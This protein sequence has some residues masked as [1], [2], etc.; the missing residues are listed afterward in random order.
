[1]LGKGE[2]QMKKTKKV[3]AILMALAICFALLA[4]CGDGSSDTPGGNQ[5][6]TS[7]GNTAAPPPTQ[8][9]FAPGQA[10][11]DAPAR[12]DGNFGEEIIIIVDNNAV[13]VLDPFMPG[14]GAPA[15][16][17]TTNL[18]FDRLIYP[19]GGGEY[20]PYLATRWET[21]DYKTFTFWLR[22]DVYFHNGEKFNAH[23]VVWTVN[24]AGEDMAGTNYS[25]W[26]PVPVVRVEAIEEYV[27]QIELQSVFIDYIFNI[28]QPYCLIVNEKA[29]RDDPVNGVMVGTGAFKFMEFVPS[30]YWI[31][32]RNDNYWSDLAIT[33]KITF[34]FIP[35]QGART[36]MMLNRE[37]E[38][39]FGIGGDDMHIFENH[40]DFQLYPFT[41]N[42]NNVLMFNLDDP[43]LSDYNLRM[44]II[45]GLNRADIAVVAAGAY[46]APVTDGNVWG[47]ETEF[48]L[49]DIPMI[50]EDENLAREFLA[51]SNYNG[52]PIEI[53][54]SILTNTRAAEMVQQLLLPLGINITLN[55]MDGAGLTAYND[56][57]NNQ[58]QLVIHVA[59]HT[60]AASSTRASVYPGMNANR[61]MYNNPQVTALYDR[62]VV[63]TDFNT[64]RDL[65]HQIQRILAEDPPRIN[66]FWRLNAAVAVHGIGGFSL[67]STALYDF[68]YL[69]WDLDQY[70]S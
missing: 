44:A 2:Y 64:R 38:L 12:Q 54:T 32:E 59:V 19:L 13:S 70:G 66:L 43:L 5:P 8:T 65:Y 33:R 18:I 36:V 31:V 58:S 61:V 27:V 57:A 3:V 25:F 10:A 47:Y 1:M 63:E 6:G 14:A 16:S 53:A 60:E 42:N 26:H 7:G 24:K 21:T 22:D 4:A 49:W 9:P 23:D 69:Y 11:P 17:W 52:E 67:P 41:F 50:A 30:N 39:C 28:A 40:D 35:E 46:A 51:R 56:P 68:R 15:N 48:R 55:V 62:A 29:M 34:R 20:A 37:A 45:H